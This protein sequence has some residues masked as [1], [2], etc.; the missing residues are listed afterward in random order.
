MQ[1]DLSS[2][3][4]FSKN[5]EEVTEEI[6]NFCKSVYIFDW[7]DNDIF[8]EIMQAAYVINYKPWES[9]IN[10]WDESNGKAYVILE[11]EA[12]VSIESN[13]IATL[14]AW[15]IFW[16]YAIICEEN[17]SASVSAR[18]EL[19][20]LVIDKDSLLLLANEDFKINNILATRVEKNFDSNVWGIFKE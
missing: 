9:I 10:E 4:E 20:C 13:E 3:R 5:I 11:W 15:S 17:R 6:K 7:I 14:S 19:K 8:N 18:T 2:M 12:I 1:L 16:E